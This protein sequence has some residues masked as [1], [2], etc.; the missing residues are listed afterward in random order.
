MTATVGQ[1]EATLA[2]RFS[3]MRAES[4]DRN[5]LLVGDR[6]REITGVRLALDPTLEVVERAR[7]AGDNVVVT[8][9]P[10]ALVVPPAIVAGPGSGGVLFAALDTGIAL[11][12]AHTTLD[13]DPIAQRRLPELLGLEFQRHVESGFATT[14]VVTVYVPEAETARVLDAM[15]AAGAGE[16]GDYDH[17]SFDVQGTGRFIAP[18][19]SSPAY[20]TAGSNTTVSERRVE[21]VCPPAGVA[22]VVAA[23]V[24]AHPYEEP[25]VTVSE[26]K[27]ARNA[28]SLGA[29]CAAPSG[30]TLRSLA[31][32][33]V[34][35]F[36]R[37][38]RVWGGAD[39]G[40]SIVA[41]ATGSAGS[42]IDDARRQGADVLLGG[43]VRYH[44]AMA[45]G[46]PVIELGHDVSE[47]PLVDVLADAVRQ[48]PGL[49]ASR[50]TV[51]PPTYEWWAPS[52]P[53]DEER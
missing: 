17:C 29:L 35:V 23:C 47:W 5:G 42:L 12:N 48:T 11:V 21:V 6:E 45:A 44:D 33:C 31:E 37:A 2:E 32:R 26:R 20:G 39:V 51:E 53:T 8:H 19:G 7:E 3:Y 38:P 9:H 4:W 27:L 52:G 14:S 16:I 41:T 34:E 28:A 46:I 25:L 49:D 24:A 40:V 10:A 36:G 30:M 18:D 43:E 15:W 13:R 50:V 22:K 1:L